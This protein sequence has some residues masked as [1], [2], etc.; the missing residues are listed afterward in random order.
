MPQKRLYIPLTTA[1][2]AR[3]RELAWA[4]RRSPR[5]YAALLLAH[6]LGCDEFGAPA[7]DY[8]P[9]HA[10]PA[11]ASDQCERRQVEGEALA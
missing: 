9:A 8:A 7:T 4:E 3:L 10:S 6:A 11:P 2:F 1:E 5:D